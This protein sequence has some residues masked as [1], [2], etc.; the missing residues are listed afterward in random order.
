MK[1]KRRPY[2]R[3]AKASRGSSLKRSPYLLSRKKIG[4]SLS[5]EAS[6]AQPMTSSPAFMLFRLSVR[7]ASFIRWPSAST[8]T[9]LKNHSTS[10]CSRISLRPPPFALVLADP[11]L[12]S[13]SPSVRFTSFSPRVMKS[14]ATTI[15]IHA[16]IL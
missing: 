1:R 5:A 11:L 16:P 3:L 9:Q 4:I 6:S 14:A 13:G 12:L 10:F 8:N 2:I 7:K 15:T